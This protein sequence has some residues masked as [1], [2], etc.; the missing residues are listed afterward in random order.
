MIGTIQH[1]QTR[2]HTDTQRRNHMSSKEL[3]PIYSKIELGMTRDEILFVLASEDMRDLVSSDFEPDQEYV[4]KIF[5]RRHSRSTWSRGDGNEF[6]FYFDAN[7]RL[8]KIGN[9]PYIDY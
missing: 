9:V 1:V 7:A 3:D 5:A 6:H 4:S 8:V 2:H